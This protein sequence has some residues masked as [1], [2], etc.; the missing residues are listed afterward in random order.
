MRL[1]NKKD[2]D[3]WHN[4][5]F[6]IR[7]NNTSDVRISSLHDIVYANVA[8]WTPFMIAYVCK[9]KYSETMNVAHYTIER[10]K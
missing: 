9:L 10:T 4:T 8:I 5:W 1:P 2:L 6:S 3:V 7:N